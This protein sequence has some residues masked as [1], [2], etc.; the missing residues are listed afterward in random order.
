MNKGKGT[1]PFTRVLLFTGVTDPFTLLELLSISSRNFHKFEEQFF[2][3]LGVLE[4]AHGCL[5]PSYIVVY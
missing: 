2:S 3:L 5:N 1:S 4:Q